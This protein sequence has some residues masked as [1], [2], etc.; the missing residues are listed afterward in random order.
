MSKTVKKFFA[1]AI[2]L[3]MLVTVFA[4][5]KTAEKSTD[6]KKTDQTK[7][8]GTIKEEGVGKPDLL[9]ITRCL[10]FGDASDNPDLKEEWP[11]VFTEKTGVN[12]KVN[13]PPRNEFMEKVYL[14][15][16]AGEL[17]GMVNV[18]TPADVLKMIED[19]TI[20][21]L[22]EY[23]KDNPTWNSMP[24]GF[25]NLFKF[26]GKIW[27]VPMGYSGSYFT[28]AIRKDWLDKLGLK[29][30]ET[31]DD[32]YEA[33]KAF[34]EKDPDGNGQN[35]TVGLVSSGTWNLQDIF[36]AFG[37][38]L[39]NVGGNSI[40]WDPN[41]N[42]WRDSMLST[43]NMVAALTYLNNMYK[44]GYLDK[45]LFTNK[46]SNMREKFWSGKYGSTF[47]WVMFGIG[48]EP[49]I[50]K[51]YPDAKVVEIPGLKGRVTE[52]LNQRVVGGAPYV[53]V[54]GTKQ[55]KEVVNAFVNLFFGNNP[56]Y[57]FMGRLGIPD[58]TFRIEGN[59]VYTLKDPKTG[60]FYAQPG[61][62]SEIPKYDSSK[63]KIIPDG[64]PEEKARAEQNIAK[65]LELDKIGYEKKLI[66]DCPN[67]ALI[68]KKYTELS[69]DINKLFNEAITKAIIGEVKPE[70]A[71]KNYV[72]Q[73]KALGADKVLEEAN[74]A[75]GQKP[76]QQY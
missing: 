26:D 72:S 16:A 27:A 52:N 54:K 5:C 43:D 46:G 8:T 41:Y 7:E 23:L 62:V 57:H 51:N 24:E 29:V 4:G 3:F 69:G 37:A 53:L 67:D 68:S 36:Q 63:Y 6:T 28:R 18:F 71:V 73:M 55:P 76:D 47:Y 66:F 13:S 61:I 74:A 1:L 31:V 59:T 2:C 25:R 75:I 34:T 70:D 42:R 38:R 44:N 19:E 50:Q 22:D 21:P 14:S 30:P 49:T 64:T 48:S 10:Y 45:E 58:K 40:A 15:L 56:E 17:K 32:L 65:R 20:E 9:E 12:T 33:A 39:N 60:Q 11:K 35:D